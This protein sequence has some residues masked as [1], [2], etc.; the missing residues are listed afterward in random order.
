MTTYNP[1]LIENF[2]GEAKT[3]AGE[4]KRLEVITSK[5]PICSEAVELLAEITERLNTLGHMADRI[6]ENMIGEAAAH[7]AGLVRSVR[8][9]KVSSRASNVSP[10]ER[11]KRQA[12]KRGAI[13]VRS[14]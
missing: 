2:R 11:A 1:Y 10:G 13:L 5:N 12:V 3:L 4:A 8:P 9:V 6:K 7:S 14:V